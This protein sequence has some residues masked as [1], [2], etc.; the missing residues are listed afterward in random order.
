[1]HTKY[2][3]YPL[4]NGLNPAM[5][6]RDNLLYCI[7]ANAAPIDMTLLSCL[8]SESKIPNSLQISTLWKPNTDVSHLYHDI[9]PPV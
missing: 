3:A 1:M 8:S 2:N 7:Q 9:L 4:R 5:V 6:R